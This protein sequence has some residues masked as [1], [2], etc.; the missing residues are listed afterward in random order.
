M[1]IQDLG[2][3]PITNYFDRV[4]TTNSKF[5]S[6]HARGKAGGWQ[7]DNLEIIKEFNN[8]CNGQNTIKQVK[9]V[10]G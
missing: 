9:K 8:H 5:D 10:M 3:D 6:Y 4:F 2:N 1:T 7:P